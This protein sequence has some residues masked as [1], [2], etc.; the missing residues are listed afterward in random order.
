M[1]EFVMKAKVIEA[2]LADEIYVESAATSTEELGSPVY[3]GTRKVLERLGVSC[4]GKVARRMTPRDYDVFDL[5][6]GMDERN[7]I[8]MNRI[9]R[10]GDPAHK[11]CRLLDFTDTPGD[12]SDPWFHGDFEATHRLVDKGCEALLERLKDELEYNHDLWMN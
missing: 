2:G 7:V 1:A 6:V 8:N 9:V 3:Y 11:I 12:I 4:E 10:N 5:L